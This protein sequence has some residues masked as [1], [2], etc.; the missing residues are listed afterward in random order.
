M[1][2]KRVNF[3]M[4][5]QCHALLKSVCALKGVS[6]SEYVY[7]VLSDDFHKLIR[8]DNQVQTMFLS[9]TYREGS[10]AYLLKELLIEELEES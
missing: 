1:N 2:Q 9:G 8:E 5:D 4:E 3:N 6:V 10:K 7:K